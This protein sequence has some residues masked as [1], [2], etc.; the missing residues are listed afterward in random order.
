MV[1]VLT[2][3]LDPNN[4]KCCVED[5]ECYRSQG[6]SGTC[7]NTGSSVCSQWGGYFVR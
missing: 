6:S 4:V 1:E 3:I 7:L 2:F 5:F